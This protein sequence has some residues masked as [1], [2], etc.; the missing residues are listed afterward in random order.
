MSLPVAAVREVATGFY[1]RVLAL[2]RASDIPFLVGGGYALER[3]IGIR[4]PACDFDVFVLPEDA[5][6]VLSVCGRHGYMTRIV[7]PHWLGKVYYRKQHVDVIFNSGNGAVR[8][9]RSW[10]DHGVVARVLGH[11]ALLCPPEE[12]IWSKSYV[13]E[14]ERF[15]GADVLHLIRAAGARLDWPRLISRFGEGWRILLAHLVLFGF[16][17]PNERTR[18][19]AEVM[20]EL[21]ARLDEGDRPGVRVCMGTLLSRTQYLADL[22]WGYEDGR[23][24][25]GTMSPEHIE[26]WTAAAPRVARGA[27]DDGTRAVRSSPRPRR[28]RSAP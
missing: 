21:M 15:D 27:G 2:L 9:D 17:Y 16:V 11:P 19:P 14:R 10:F 3:Y 26:R 1:G 12:M 18:V 8:V 4:R 24:V 22:A 6:R 7:H 28:R 25:L 13:M 20:R 23:L 5:P